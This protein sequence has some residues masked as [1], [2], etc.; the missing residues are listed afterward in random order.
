MKTRLVTA[1]IAVGIVLTAACSPLKIIMNSTDPNG[2]RYVLTSDQSLFS[3]KMG[4]IKVA[5]GAKIH[6]RDTVLAILITSDA[7]TDH[8]IFDMNDRLLI[9]FADQSVLTLKNIYD[10]E[11]ETET[12]TTQTQERV[13]TYGYDYVYSPWTDNVYVTPYEAYSFVP[14][15]YVTKTTNSYA[16]Y[17]LTKTQ[18]LDI[19]NKNVIK[20]RVEVENNEL[21]MPSPGSTSAI[22][23]SIYACLK[24]GINRQRSD[25]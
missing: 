10:R 7:N 25:F 22:F 23:S 16:L 21:D 6:Q 17:L 15:T 2:D 19:I 11:F 24:E 13:S 14:R 5:L 4:H 20:L 1:A 18:L 8:G 9:R 3:S 12:T